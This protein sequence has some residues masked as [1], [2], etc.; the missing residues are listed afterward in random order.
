MESI[1]SSRNV[2]TDLRQGPRTGPIVSYCACPHP[3]TSPVP[4]PCSVNRRWH[5]YPNSNNVNKASTEF[6]FLSHTLVGMVL[7]V[8]LHL[9]GVVRLKLKRGWGDRSDE[10]L[11]VISEWTAVPQDHVPVLSVREVT[12]A[13]VR[14]EI[15]I[16]QTWIK[17]LGWENFTRWLVRVGQSNATCFITK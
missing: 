16:K 5:I 4:F 1:L 12:V 6:W 11:A 9:H 15:K 2:H 17:I 7:H 13:Q 8:V 10:L 14:S 3:C